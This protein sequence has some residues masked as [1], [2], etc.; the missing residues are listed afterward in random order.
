MSNNVPETNIFGEAVNNDKAVE[1]Q[2][3]SII[4]NV[5]FLKNCNKLNDFIRVNL[6]VPN[7]NIFIKLN[8]IFSKN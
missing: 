2:F 5:Q 6:F 3:E 1:D 4:G 7:P 8:I